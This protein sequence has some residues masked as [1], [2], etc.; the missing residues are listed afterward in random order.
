MS[1]YGIVLGAAD[2]LLADNPEIGSDSTVHV[3][4]D[5][6]VEV[7]DISQIIPASGTLTPLSGVLDSVLGNDLQLVCTSPI[8]SA[9]AVA[10]TLAVV[11][12]DASSGQATATFAIPTYAKNQTAHLPQGLAADF[13]GAGAGAGKKIKQVTSL[14]SVVG[15]EN[16]N[17]FKVVALPELTSFVDI[18]CKRSANETLPIPKS[19]PIPCGKNGSAF[20]R[21]GRSDPG[22][23]EV[24]AMSFGAADGL[25]RLAGHRVTTMVE[26]RKEGGV[27][28]QRSVYGGWICT[29]QTPR[30]DGDDEVVASAEGNFELFGMFV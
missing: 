2:L 18:G 6:V 24:S 26:V 1:K 15:G 22:M 23:L 28:T 13:V 16:G 17:R 10:V 12:A 5:P 20:T 19:L 14:V 4:Y 7:A 21:R 9:T 11:F 25:A 29:P 8:R 27:L 3:S 30:G